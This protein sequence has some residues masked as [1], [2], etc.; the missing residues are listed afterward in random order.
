VAQVKDLCA[1][2]C[3]LTV[4]QN[5]K[6]GKELIEQRDF[7]ELQA[8]FQGTFEIGRRY[9]VMNP[10]KMRDTYGKLMY[11]LMDSVEPEIQELLGFKCA[12]PLCTVYS[13]LEEHGAD[14][15]LRDPNISTAIAE[16]TTD[17]KSRHQVQP[18]G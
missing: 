7:Q 3:G 9:K 11:M 14:R 18:R 1:I 13:F 8:F 4:A 17:G 16:I 2:L 12:R 6:K 15:L 10:D 5:F